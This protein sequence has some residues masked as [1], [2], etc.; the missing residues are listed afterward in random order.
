MASSVIEIRGLIKFYG[1]QPVLRG[2][3]L[4]V[5]AGHTHALL[6]RNGAGKSTT[7]NILMGLLERDAGSVS[8]LQMDP[9]LLPLD[10]RRAVGFLA[11]DQQMF[12]WMSVENML[13]FM[14]PF[15]PTWDM[16]LA[17]E[18]VRQFELPLPQT[19]GRLSKG[20]Q[21]RLGLI[22]ALAH[23]PQLVILDD[24]ALGLDPIVRREFNR[25]LITHLQGQ[26]AAVL[27]SSHLLSEVEPIADMISILKDG[28][29]CRQDS[30]ER[31]RA[32]VKQLVL[33][34]VAFANH[35]DLLHVLDA[36]RFEGEYAVT[37]TKFAD[38]CER[39]NAIGERFHVNELT[40]DDIFAAYVAGR[41]DGPRG[42]APALAP[43]VSI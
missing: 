32:D 25:D 21:V 35:R 34:E 19:I 40:L 20:Q 29:I 17:M 16:T 30:P 13:R 23:R 14:Q 6:G 1:K 33:S 9:A 12:D 10:V 37:V 27:Y 28:V 15:Y 2:L 31:L 22:L 41:V 7:L 36:Q 39:L 8:V 42:S 38:T 18:Y 11:E 26:G 5:Q 4:D 43:S 24:P 3:D